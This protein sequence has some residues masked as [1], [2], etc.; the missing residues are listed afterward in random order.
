MRESAGTL[1]GRSPPR[2]YA[3]PIDRLLANS[4]ISD[5]NF[6]T[7]P[8]DG[9]TSPC[10]EW[11]GNLDADGYARITIR[12]K[13]GPRKGKSRSIKVSRYIVKVIHGKYLGMR[14][15]AKHMCS[16]RACANPSH[17]KGGTHKSNMRQC[18]AEGSH[19]TP[20]RDPKVRR[21]ALLKRMHGEREPGSDD[22]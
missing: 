13:G 21:Q 11:T 5:S 17:H 8:S 18:V 12:W 14:Y 22:E 19:F 4:V 3:S 20:F 1:V 9:E 2:P 10:W 7:D 6:W 16:N 15:V